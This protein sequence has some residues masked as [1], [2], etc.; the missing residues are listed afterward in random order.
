MTQCEFCGRVLVGRGLWARDDR[1]KV[2]M[3]GFCP[4]CGLLEKM[5]VEREER[6]AIRRKLRARTVPKP[7]PAAV[8]WTQLTRGK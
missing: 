6:R 7:N 2:T 3:L 5:R 8:D 4:P 1:A